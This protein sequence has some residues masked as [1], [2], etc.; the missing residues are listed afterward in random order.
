[1]SISKESRNQTRNAITDGASAYLGR[2][3]KS[4]VFYKKLV[5]K[6]PSRQAEHCTESFSRSAGAV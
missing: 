1:M 3:I 5:V 2:K 6:I 4:T